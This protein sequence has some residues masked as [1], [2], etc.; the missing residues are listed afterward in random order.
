M[1]LLVIRLSSLGDIILATPIIRCL[2]KQ[3]N[4]E[5]HFLTKEGGADLL[6]YNP[7]IDR[8]IVVRKSPKER[9]EEI[10]ANQYDHIIDL[11][12]NFRTWSFRLNFIGKTSTFPKL[13]LRKWILV[14]FKINLLPK[15]HVV[16]RYFKAV[17]RLGVTNDGLPCDVFTSPI[18]ENEANL[19]SRPFLFGNIMV[20]GAMHYTKQIPAELCVKIINHNPG[21]WLLLGGK[22]DR[23]KADQIAL[24]CN[25]PTVNACGMLSFNGSIEAMRNAKVVVTP[26][27]GLMHAAAALGKNIISIWGNTVP[28][29]GMYPYMPNLPEHYKIIEVNDLSCRPCS[30]IG[31]NA[32]P[33]KHF[34]CMHLIDASDIMIKKNKS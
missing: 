22:N 14:N 21:N 18:E 6:K 5:I 10:L 17:K 7:Y 32:C 30:K 1:K 19:I 2:K 27:T 24:L 29:F 16:E 4:A 13:N 28:N 15:V 25:Q 23:L 20:I 33:K 26:D 11:Q 9:T 3:L 12:N 34:N 31:H 8:I